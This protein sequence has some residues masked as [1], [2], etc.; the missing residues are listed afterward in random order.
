MYLFLYIILFIFSVW[1]LTH[2]SGK[3]PLKQFLFNDCFYLRLSFVFCYLNLHAV[4]LKIIVGSCSAFT[5]TAISLWRTNIIHDF[6]PMTFWNI[7]WPSFVKTQ[8]YVKSHDFNEILH[9]KCIWKALSRCCCMLESFIML[10]C[11]VSLIQ[12]ILLLYTDRTLEQ[13]LWNFKKPFMNFL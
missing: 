2:L 13:G 12:S 7:N 5:L 4:I 1:I 3:W 11:Y 6:T 10:L 9:V 8:F